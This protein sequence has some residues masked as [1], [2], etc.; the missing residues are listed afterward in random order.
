MA[1]ISIR[2]ETE[3]VHLGKVQWNK[4]GSASTKETANKTA[5]WTHLIPPASSY[6]KKGSEKDV[7]SNPMSFSTALNVG[8]CSKSH[9]R[10][11]QMRWEDAEIYSFSAATCI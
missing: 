7:F 1:L 9:I 10:P 5:I 6:H 2:S 11:D 4:K 3:T 8:L